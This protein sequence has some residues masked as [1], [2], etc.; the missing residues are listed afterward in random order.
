MMRTSTRNLPH[1]LVGRMAQG[2]LDC[3][4]SSTE[5]GTCIGPCRFRPTLV[6]EVIHPRGAH[7]HLIPLRQSLLLVTWNHNNRNLKLQII[8]VAHPFLR[9]TRD[10]RSL[11]RLSEL[12][13]AGHF[14]F[15][16]G[17]S[18][19]A[20]RHHPRHPQDRARRVQEH[21]VKT[22]PHP[23]QRP[24]R[25]RH[26]GSGLRRRPQHF[27]ARAINFS[28]QRVLDISVQRKGQQPVSIPTTA[29]AWTFKTPG[30]TSAFITDPSDQRRSPRRQLRVDRYSLVTSQE[31]VRGLLR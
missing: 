19:R 28:A 5:I 15:W 25:G 21:P 18:T 8:G 13:I 14:S 29:K 22:A 6:K 30:S 10:L 17:R 20:R 24:L 3:R 26:T 23:R 11:L 9:T 12:A 2:S 31:K 27:G 16:W 1:L 7:P 4:T